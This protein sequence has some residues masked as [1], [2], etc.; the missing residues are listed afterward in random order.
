MENTKDYEA[1]GRYHSA[2]EQFRTL[3][4]QRHNLAGSIKRLLDTAF[5]A[6]GADSVYR[7]DHTE[8]LRKSEELAKINIDLENAIQAADR[9]AGAASKRPLHRI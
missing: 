8:F 4:A 1:I 2:M 3:H 9:Y 5:I 6:S 7:F